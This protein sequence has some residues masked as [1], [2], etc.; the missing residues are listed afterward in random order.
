MDRTEAISLGELVRRHRERAGLTQEELAERVG[1]GVSVG[2]ISNIERGRTRPYR[3]TLDALATALVV[4]DEE[5]AALLAAWSRQASSA[6]G[7]PELPAPPSAAPLPMALTP[8]VGREQEEALLLD[9]VLW[10]GVRLL[11]LTGP[12]GVGKTRLALRVA[13][14]LRD[15][16]A[17][18]ACFVDLSALREAA[19]VL[20]AIARARGLREGGGQRIEDRLQAMLQEQQL[21]L[22][23]DNFEQVAAAGTALAALLAACPRGVPSRLA[24]WRGQPG[25]AAGRL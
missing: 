20:P 16:F 17:D 21:L 9:L 23:L 22:L 13:D 6:T 18:G 12:G 1:G 10:Q 7:Q 5:R 2:T 19:L 24:A 25:L 8:L 4:S 3:H 14:S 11:T 15:S